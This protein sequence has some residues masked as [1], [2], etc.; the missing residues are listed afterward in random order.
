[1]LTVGMMVLK[2]PQVSNRQF[3]FSFLMKAKA[4]IRYLNAF[5]IKT[6]Y[7]SGNTG[8]SLSLFVHICI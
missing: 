1:M 3:R 4:S 6:I 8:L 2:F 7:A 5:E